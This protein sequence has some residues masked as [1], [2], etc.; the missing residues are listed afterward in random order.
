MKRI[1]HGMLWL[2]LGGF[3][4]PAIAN[5]QCPCFTQVQLERWLQRAHQAGYPL[6]G[7]DPPAG[8]NS[9]ANIIFQIAPNGCFQS[10][11]SNTL[12]VR[13]DATPGPGDAFCRVDTNNA[14]GLEG[15]PTGRQDITPDQANRCLTLI[16]KVCGG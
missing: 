10:E 15:I 2:F 16:R 7:C 12:N 14:L 5:A 11:S 6:C 3:L 13:T 8:P 1:T 4:L 9:R